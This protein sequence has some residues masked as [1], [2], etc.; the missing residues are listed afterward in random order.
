MSDKA[1]EKSCSPASDETNTKLD[2]LTR[3]VANLNEI[4]NQVI[5]N[6]QVEIKDMKIQNAA[7]C[8]RVHSIY[9]K[10][11]SYSDHSLTCST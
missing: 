3:L 10:L 8:E 9:G 11:D 2:I 7:F 6:V 1:F 5:E 4:M